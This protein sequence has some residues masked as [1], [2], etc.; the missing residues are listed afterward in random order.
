MSIRLLPPT[1]NMPSL[2]QQL[3][4]SFAKLHADPRGEPFRARFRETR[5]QWR[6]LL[7]QENDL[8]DVVTTSQ[9]EV[10]YADFEADVVVDEVD[11]V[12]GSDEALRK[13]LFNG[14]PP[15]I[16]KRPIAGAQL[17]AMETWQQTLLNAKASEVSALALKCA[18]AVA[19]ARDAVK[20]RSEANR[21]LKEFY[22]TSG[23]RDF[24]DKLNALRVEVF[25]YFDQL[26]VSNPQLKLSRQYARGF[27][28]QSPEDGALSLE[29]ELT[30]VQAEAEEL[31]QELALKEERIKE[32][33][34]RKEAAEQ[35]DA[36]EQERQSKIAELERELTALRG[37]GRR[38]R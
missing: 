5:D 8:Q 12:V 17:T 30:I 36:K 16:F 2:R 6:A 32:L 15:S 29:E 25:N 24:I 23:R 11:S 3:I 9:A 4:Y 10:E 35:E 1:T 31:R 18:T 37:S 22:V 20:R 19:T 13:L 33:I 26:V 38:R 7:I 21:A 34:A 28:L 14:K 27:F